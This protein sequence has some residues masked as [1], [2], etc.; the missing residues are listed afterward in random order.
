MKTSFICLAILI[1][2]M[3][4]LQNR[5]VVHLQPHSNSI[6]IGFGGELLE[7]T[8][9]PRVINLPL[10]PSEGDYQKIPWTLDIKNLGPVAVT[11]AGKALFS[12]RINV[13]QTVRIYWNGMAYS[14]KQ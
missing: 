8:G 1:G 12:V 10:F 3:N 14:F 9:A 13:G 6:D 4:M 5:P 11:V 2:Q 7:L